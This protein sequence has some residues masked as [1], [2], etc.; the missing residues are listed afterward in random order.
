MPRIQDVL[1]CALLL[2]AV[3]QHAAAETPA[4]APAP[5]ATFDVGSLH[6]AQY[7][8]GARTV[9][10]VP[11]LACGPWEWSGQ[12]AR[13]A[14][15]YT[16][17]A[18]TLPGFDGRP[19]VGGPLFAGTTG[20]FWRLLGEKHINR[21]IVIGHSLGGTFAFM[22]ATQH[23]DRLGGVVSL[24]G[25]PVFP[26][27]LFMPAET[28][29][30]MAQRASA[31]M[32]AMSPAQFT[33]YERS[34]VLPELVTSPQDV[35]AIAAEVGKSDPAD[36]GR[37][38][39]EDVTLDLRPALH[40]ASLPILVLAP[41]DATA[42]AQYHIAS[43]DAKRGFYAQILKGAPNLDIVMI[44]SSRHF[45]MYDQPTAVGDAIANFLSSHAQ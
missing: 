36:T 18:L 34:T 13:F 35:A 5:V 11:G 23:P 25:L 12:I 39:E 27:A 15:Q 8:T 32:A 4:A 16:I 38:F 30:A 42:D 24:D 21:P 26:A 14:S 20:D 3:P 28:I 9:I 7:G 10:F 33:D 2:T 41:Y 37:W 22:L 43:M 40:K 17:Y 19:S 31:Q 1:A 44:P 6:V 45:A 29:K